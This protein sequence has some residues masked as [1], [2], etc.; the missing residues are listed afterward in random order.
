MGSCCNVLFLRKPV[1]LD[2]EAMANDILTL[3][4]NLWKDEQKTIP[5]PLDG[6]TARGA[7]RNINTQQVVSPTLTVSIFANS[8]VTNI[9][10]IYPKADVENLT[11]NVGYIFDLSV[12]NADTGDSFTV[13]TGILTLKQG[14][15]S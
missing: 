3:P 9:T 5:Y 15:S 7:L 2:V 8:T 11:Y 14:A 4:I 1:I 13:W 6:Y 10:G 12:D